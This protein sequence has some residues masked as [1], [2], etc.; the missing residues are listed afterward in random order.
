[1]TELHVLGST[2]YVLY[3]YVVSDTG[4]SYSISYHHHYHLVF[5]CGELAIEFVAPK[6][7][8]TALSFSYL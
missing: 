2:V 6:L 3:M 1:M 5:P 8:T 7:V 4:S